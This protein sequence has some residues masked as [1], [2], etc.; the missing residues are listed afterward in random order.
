MKQK[1]R[2]YTVIAALLAVILAVG[3]F[4]TVIPTISAEEEPTPGPLSWNRTQSGYTYG[5]DGRI[6]SYACSLA[7]ETKIDEASGEVYD[8]VTAILDI[9]NEASAISMPINKSNIVLTGLVYYPKLDEYE[10]VVHTGYSS[11]FDHVDRWDMDI[12]MGMKD[13]GGMWYYGEIL[14]VKAEYYLNERLI[15]SMSWYREE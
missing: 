12:L 8:D 11:G 3:L 2:I 6:Y 7:F 14:Y 10:T 15:E 9:Y 13:V 1:K 4:S 5:L